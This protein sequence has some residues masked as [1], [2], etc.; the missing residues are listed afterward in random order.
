MGG[1]WTIGK[2]FGIEIRI[3]ASW[4]IIFFLI[5]WTLG[6]SYFPGQ[7]PGW[8]QPLRGYRAGHQPA[9]L[10]LGAGPR[11]IPFPGG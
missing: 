2:I 9:V 7:Y 5:T 3:D 11:A 8:G 10:R 4:L 6:G 1:T